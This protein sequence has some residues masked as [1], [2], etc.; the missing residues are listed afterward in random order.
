MVVEECGREGSSPH[1]RQEAGRKTEKGP[2]K[3]ADTKD[4]LSSDLV[5]P[6]KLHLLRF[7]KPPKITPPVRD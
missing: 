7:I 5:P 2:R 4:M 1:H 6:G 3:G